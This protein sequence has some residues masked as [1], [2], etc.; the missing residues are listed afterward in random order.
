M[1]KPQAHSD[2]LRLRVAS[3]GEVQGKCRIVLHSSHQCDG[4]HDEP[5]DVYNFSKQQVWG[6]TKGTGVV[7]RVVYDRRRIEK[8]SRQITLCRLLGTI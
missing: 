4:D 1:L 3:I 2:F 7:K 6:K 8:Q 5:T